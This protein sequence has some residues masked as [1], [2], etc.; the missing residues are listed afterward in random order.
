MLLLMPS[1]REPVWNPEPQ[2]QANALLTELPAHLDTECHDSSLVFVDESDKLILTLLATILGKRQCEK[3]E[4]KS[5]RLS[6]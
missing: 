4:D 5:N 3:G 1:V 6:F 2:D